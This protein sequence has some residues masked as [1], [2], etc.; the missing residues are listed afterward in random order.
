[1]QTQSHEKKQ[2]K[3]ITYQQIESTNS[4][5]FLVNTLK[6]YFSK[7]NINLILPQVSSLKASF[8]INNEDEMIGFNLKGEV[9]KYGWV[10]SGKNWKPA[11]YMKDYGITSIIEGEEAA[12][13][14]GLLKDNCHKHKLVSKLE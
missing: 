6:N 8:W 13:I 14:T 11:S 4:K 1:M 7:S 9:C 12:N 3:N 5:D 10:L 2:R